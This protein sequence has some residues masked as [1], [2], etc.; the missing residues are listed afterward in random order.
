[1][2]KLIKDLY[3]KS[4]C[5]VKKD[6]YSTSFFKYLRGVRQGC[7][8][9]P[10]LF[11]LFLNELPLTLNYKITYPVIFPNGERRNTLLYIPMI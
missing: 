8:L 7:I 6:N 10:L 9:S 5:A 1:M 2:F 3:S 4:S 11:N